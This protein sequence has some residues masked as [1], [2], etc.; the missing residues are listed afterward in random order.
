MHQTATEKRLE[1]LNELRAMAEGQAVAFARKDAMDLKQQSTD[2]RI[3]DISD[4]LH[5]GMARGIAMKDAWGYIVAA[6]GI[7][8]ALFALYIRR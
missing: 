6:V 5:Q 7:G 2:K 4:L 8:V 3:D 1:G